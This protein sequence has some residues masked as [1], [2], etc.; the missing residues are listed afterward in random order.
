MNKN[1]TEIVFVIDASGS[2]AHLVNDTIGGYNAFLRAQRENTDGI[3]KVTT[4]LFSDNTKTICENV[5]VREAAD[6]TSMQYVPGGMTAL[7]DAVGQTIESMQNRHDNMNEE[8]RPAN[9][10][11]V[12]TTDGQENA[13]RTFDKDK[14]SKMITHQTKGHG[15]KFMYLGANVDSFAEASSI[16][17]SK[18][19]SS[20][21]D[22]SGVGT[23]AV[24]TAVS[25]IACSA[26]ACADALCDTDI[27]L[28]ACYAD[29]LATESKVDTNVTVL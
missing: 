6:M 27:S 3:A 17:I 26:R 8:D 22:Y 21:Y 12:I 4:V 24:Y 13:S 28:S 18:D 20:N 14:L 2:M 5:D 16:G 23:K 7:L 19:W 1:L 15:W 11:F 10:I 29:A 25:D 9:V